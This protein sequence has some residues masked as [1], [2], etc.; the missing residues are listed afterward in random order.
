[1]NQDYFVNHKGEKKKIQKRSPTWVN[2][3]WNSVLVYSSFYIGSFSANCRFIAPSPKKTTTQV[4]KETHE[5]VKKDNKVIKVALIIVG[6]IT[7]AILIFLIAW[8][9]EGDG[10][11]GF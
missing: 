3:W 9:I 6:V 7:L 10:I 5:G 4:A 8:A 11:V 1:M 2:Y